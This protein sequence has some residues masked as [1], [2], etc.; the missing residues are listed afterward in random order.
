MSDKGFDLEVFLIIKE[1]EVFKPMSASERG[2]FE[3]CC[4]HTVAAKYNGMP[5]DFPLSLKRVGETLH[6][7]FFYHGLQVGYLK[8]STESEWIYGGFGDQEF[9][10]AQL[11]A[12]D[13]TIDYSLFKMR[14]ARDNRKQGVV[15][16]D[17]FTYVN[18]CKAGLVAGYQLPEVPRLGANCFELAVAECVKANKPFIVVGNSGRHIPALEQAR[19]AY[20]CIAKEELKFFGNTFFYFFCGP[21]FFLTPIMKAFTHDLNHVGFYDTTSVNNISGRSYP[22][23]A[24]TSV[25]RGSLDK[26]YT[27]SLAVPMLEKNALAIQHVLGNLRPEHVI[28]PGDGAGTGLQVAQDLGIPCHSGDIVP[29]HPDVAHETLCET[30]EHCQ[31]NSVVVLSRVLQFLNVNE[32][33]ALEKHRVVVIDRHHIPGWQYSMDGLFST[34]FWEGISALPRLYDRSA[35][36]PPPAFPLYLRNAAENYVVRL[37]D[38]HLVSLMRFLSLH[39]RKP[40][41]NVPGGQVS[42]VRAHGHRPLAK[43]P[44][45]T[46]VVAYDPFHDIDFFNGVVALDRLFLWG[47]PRVMTVNH[48]CVLE[49]AAKII[50][51]GGCCYDQAPYTYL[52]F[53]EV[54]DYIVTYR[55]VRFAVTISA[56]VDEVQYYC[57]TVELDVVSYGDDHL[58]GPY[59]DVEKKAGVLDLSGHF[60][61][62]SVSSQSNESS[63]SY[64]VDS[65]VESE[66]DAERDWNDY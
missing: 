60:A 42:L 57:R 34:N 56:A 14:L 5:F 61:S 20:V 37:D 54:G 29:R 6:V 55:G 8:N 31:L 28:F 33:Q 25:E 45:G 1:G 59:M 48:V 49:G 65:T 40:G 17:L 7:Q 43:P 13:V 22:Y 27:T 23:P 66:D 19:V 16:P 3:K 41:L 18:M 44:R 24:L 26:Y 63:L 52:R 9:T 32:R 50:S 36:V 62:L 53:R 38:G 39:G 12:L 46:L 21:Y 35:Y 11:S 2:R 47:L 4:T 15:V 64:E 58:L 30:L 51:P 10:L